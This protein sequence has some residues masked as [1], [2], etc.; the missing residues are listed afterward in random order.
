MC[1]DLTYHSGHYRENR[2]IG[3]G[4]KWKTNERT[5][6]FERK[7]RVRLVE[8]VRQGRFQTT[9]WKEADRIWSRVE[10][11]VLKEEDYQE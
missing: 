4:R 5:A 6:G 8:A 7:A 10:Y 11:G 2:W 1:Y 9:L 3:S